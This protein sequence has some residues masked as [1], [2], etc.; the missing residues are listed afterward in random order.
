M[1]FVTWDVGGRDKTVSYFHHPLFLVLSVCVGYNVETI[2]HII[3]G[4]SFVT[5]DVSG[6]DGIV[7][8]RYLN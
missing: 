7:S 4:V 3:N 2:K 5:W 1:S 8:H 6:R